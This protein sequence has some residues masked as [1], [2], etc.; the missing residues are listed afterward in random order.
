MSASGKCLSKMSAPSH[1]DLKAIYFA[2]LPPLIPLL[3]ARHVLPDVEPS[4]AAT[5]A[6]TA[7]IH[8]SFISRIEYIL[9]NPL[10][11]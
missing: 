3:L 9:F 8:S 4:I 6:L 5:Q 2:I 1:P 7:P 11:S 10:F